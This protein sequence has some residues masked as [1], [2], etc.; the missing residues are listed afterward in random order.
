[1]SCCNIS[2]LR[3]FA[4]LKKHA[5][6]LPEGSIEEYTEIAIGCQDYFRNFIEELMAALNCCNSFAL[7]IYHVTLLI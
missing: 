3:R 6:I 7:S 2:G 1:V 5:S 4:S